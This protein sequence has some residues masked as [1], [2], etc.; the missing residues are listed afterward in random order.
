MEGLLLSFVSEAAYSN[1]T[2]L[3]DVVSLPVPP[4][5]TACLSDYSGSLQRRPPTLEEPVTLD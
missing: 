1:G 5:V 2:V 4:P 3:K